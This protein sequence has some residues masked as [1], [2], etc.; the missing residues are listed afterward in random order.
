MQSV[1][2]TICVH[3]L[4]KDKYVSQGLWNDGFWELPIISKNKTKLYNTF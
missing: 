2:V 4:A 1:A 3:D